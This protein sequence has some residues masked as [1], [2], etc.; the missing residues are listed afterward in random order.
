MS[1]P[2]GVE[3]TLH[4]V[5]RACAEGP[6]AAAPAAIWDRGR[7][8]YGDWWA[9]ARSFAAALEGGGF[10]TGQTLGLLSP[11]GAEWLV[12]AL[13]GMVAGGSV[14]PLNT[15][16]RRWEV[17]QYLEQLAP[18]ALVLT[19]AF[20]RGNFL[21]MVREL[22]PEAWEEPPGEWRSARFPRLRQLVVIGPHEGLPAGAR[23][24]AD[25]LDQPAAAAETPTAP[26]DVALVLWTSG[27]TARPKA[28]PLLQ[29]DA[30]ENGKLA[31]E[32][33]DLRP[34]DRVFLPVPLSW[35]YGSVNAL[36]TVAAAGAA[37]VLQERF[38]PGEALKL[39]ER[40]QATMAYLL[41]PITEALLAD[42]AFSR[43]RTR[44]LRGG[45]TIGTPHDIKRAARDLGAAEITNVYGGT[46]A[47]GTVCGTFPDDPLELRASTQGMPLP[48]FELRIWDPESDAPC[49][50]RE[51]GEIQ[52]RGRLT[53]G[54]LVDAAA[55]ELARPEG[56]FT[57]DGFLC[58]GDLGS[59]DQDGRLRFLGRARDVVR[60]AEINVS[61]AEVE[62]F[63]QRQLGVREAAV[64][65]VAGAGERGDALVAFV[66]PERD[67]ID[68]DAL[69]RSCRENLA[70]YKAPSR[71]VVVSR[72]PRTEVGK[73]QRDALLA[74]AERALA[75]D[76]K[77]FEVSGS[78]KE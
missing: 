48:G 19:P 51:V 21:A 43:E 9:Q 59:L 75:G 46:E 40:E 50:V 28:V 60:I 13:G 44:S 58:F 23:S 36:M 54:Y 20:G 41:P 6:G 71:L 5:V 73:V 49:A 30:I 47:Y 2:A 76:V 3:T 18:S 45:V 64:I 12:A 69:L 26:G 25:C 1:A 34:D 56:T 22:V 55:G 27:T 63:L 7:L 38:E 15:W 74:E 10:G 68:A 11:N 4:G 52:I 37:L 53:P 29:G 42:P 57:P 16:A 65:G 39:I 24:L 66:V 72:I 31:G 17:E 14:A 62:A 67:G 33:I 32:R 78:G 70:S 8:T 35:S 61:P 77:A